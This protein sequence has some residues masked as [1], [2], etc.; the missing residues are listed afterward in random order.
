MTT[1]SHHPFAPYI[2]EDATKL[3]IG[4]IPPFRF[5]ETNPE[6]RKDDVFFYYG[7]N[8]NSFWE[9][10]GEAI[11]KKFTYT[12][13]ESSI[14]ERKEALR[15]LKMGITDII[16]SCI[17]EN[18]ESSDSKLKNITKKDIDVLLK[19][20]P[21]ID[22]LIYTS[23]FVKKLMNDHFKTYHTLT[24][25][26]PKAQSVK[27]DHKTYKVHILYSPSPSA[28]RNMGTDGKQKRLEQYKRILTQEISSYIL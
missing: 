4:T 5:C 12:N 16:E 26:Q 24:P 11:N 19:A 7:S 10:I 13:S 2:P 18:G 25:D 14:N 6:L 22:T 23:E 9:L 21:Q 27:I 3:I 20:N 15:S 8:D 17:H 28:L 1:D